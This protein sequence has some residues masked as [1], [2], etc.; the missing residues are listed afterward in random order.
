MNIYGYNKSN[1]FNQINED[2]YMISNNSIS[3]YANTNSLNNESS[4]SVY[5]LLSK[6]DSNNFL[7][8]NIAIETRKINIIHLENK[9][10]TLLS[11][12]SKLTLFITLED[13]TYLEKLNN[14][15]NEIA[16]VR[17]EKNSISHDMQQEVLTGI[18]LPVNT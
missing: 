4:K 1:N 18:A 6:T 12:K 8:N 16:K 10:N 3:S 5:F 15:N 13:E 2:F 9:L 14:L 17:E 7:E 11:E